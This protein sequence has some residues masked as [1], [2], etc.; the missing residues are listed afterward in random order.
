MTLQLA[1]YY[2]LEITY[3]CRIFLFRTP[4]TLFSEVQ[5]HPLHFYTSATDR[6]NQ[7]F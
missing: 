7:Q 2:K 5:I 3:V 6:R 1:T 4:D